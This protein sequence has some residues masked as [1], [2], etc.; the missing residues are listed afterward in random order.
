M[1]NSRPV[2]AII[3]VRLSVFRGEDDP[4]TS[5]KRQEQICRDY[6]AAKGWNVLD[7]IS[8][9]DVSGSDKG[10]R[11]DRP[12]LAEIRTRWAETDIVIFS[13]LDRMARNVVD[14]RTFAD[15]AEKNGAAL[16]SVNE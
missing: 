9:L 13:K 10:L 6:C 3:Y 16:V 2:N 14:F 4:T 11:L 5:P 1:T 8:D 7:V 12:G 15:E